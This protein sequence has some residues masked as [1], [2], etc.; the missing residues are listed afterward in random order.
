MFAYWLEAAMPSLQTLSCKRCSL[1]GALPWAANATMLP[2][3]RYLELAE[4]AVSFATLLAEGEC[5]G[6]YITL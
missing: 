2:N 3:L 5:S 4:N 6:C 1:A